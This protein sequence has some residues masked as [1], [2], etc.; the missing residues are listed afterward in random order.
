MTG[1]VG[2]ITAVVMLVWAAWTGGAGAAP[3]ETRDTG[4]EWRDL[5]ADA[6]RGVLYAAVQDR[7]AV[8]VLLPGNVSPEAVI[9]VG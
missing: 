8:W 5:V 7:D 9:P 2:L 3:F 1:R 6:P 4:A